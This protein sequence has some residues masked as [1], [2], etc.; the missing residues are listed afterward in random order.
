M[1]RFGKGAWAKCP[2]CRLRTDPCLHSSWEQS[3]WTTEL[4]VMS[5]LRRFDRAVRSLWGTRN[6]CISSWT[7][8]RRKQ[9]ENAFC[10]LGHVYVILLSL[11]WTPCC[12][13]VM[14][15]STPSKGPEWE[16]GERRKRGGTKTKQHTN[17]R[18]K[19]KFPKPS[20]GPRLKSTRPSA[21]S[22]PPK[23]DATWAPSLAHSRPPQHRRCA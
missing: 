21:C 9:R 10:I 7:W 1:I 19:C 13:F 17:L 5:L 12:L 11:L 20:F 18:R 14:P 23:C 16:E 4:D 8:Y 6:K 22:K 15:L 3:G 2:P